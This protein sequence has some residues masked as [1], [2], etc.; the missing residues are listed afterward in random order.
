MLENVRYVNCGKFICDGEWQHPDRTIDWY[1]VI[2]VTKGNVYIQESDTKYTLKKDDV[3]LLSPHKRH[4]G[5]QT[6][7]D[8]EYFWLHF[9]GGFAWPANLKHTKIENP[10]T[11]SLYFRCLVNNRVL[12]KPPEGMDYLTR[13]ILIE[14][15][16]GSVQPNTNR[17]A[18]N[19]AAWIR[20]NCHTALTETQI[21][22]HFGYNTDYINRMFKKNFFKTIKQYINDKRM[23]HIKTLM[24]SDNL[25]LGEIAAM[26]GFSEYKYFLKFFKYHEGIT[27]TEFY[28]QYAKIHIN[29]H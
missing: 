1:T 25:T 15:Y 5:Y 18:E 17:M 26:S 12:K 3:V 28:K 9:Q 2:F 21:A 20:A 27:P 11:V 4:F 29:T 19:I 8:V 16:A 13:L 14:L 24:L 6:S 7:S 23:E 22:A 10:Y